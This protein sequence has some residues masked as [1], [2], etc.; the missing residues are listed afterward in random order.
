MNQW[1]TEVFGNVVEGPVAAVEAYQIDYQTAIRN[2]LDPLKIVLT[3]SKPV[4]INILD[5]I[6]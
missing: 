6:S 1:F 5:Q 3:F 2:Q 4:E